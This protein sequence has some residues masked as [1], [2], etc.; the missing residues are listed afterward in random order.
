MS[1]WRTLSLNM[2]AIKHYKSFIQ[3]IIC[4]IMFPLV[5][6]AG[7]KTDT[8]YLQNGDRITGEVKRFEYG[9]LFFKTDA[10][11][12]LKIEFND[13]RT[14]YSNEQYTIQMANGL[15]FFGS[16][17]TSAT[18]GYVYL[19]VGSFRIPEPIS[20]IV[21]IYPVKHAFW[22]RLDGSI[23]LGYSYTKASTISKL[24][25]SG[26]VDYRV[27]KSFTSINVRSIRTDQEDRDRIRKQD[28][29]ISYRRFYKKKW[30]G[31]I[32]FCPPVFRGVGSRQGF[33]P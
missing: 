9:I 12:T 30:F 32:R 14:F 16:I 17:D 22:K 23:D 15:R 29:S 21:E 28:Y 31:S 26:N 5:S 3:L 27:E 25:F 33:C 18:N 24:N 7:A 8:V 10:M 4:F 19:K 13:I 11:G 2:D 20:A 6:Q 1:F